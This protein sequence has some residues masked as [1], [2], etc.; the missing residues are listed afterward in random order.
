MLPERAHN[1]RSNVAPPED[2]KPQWN[3]CPINSAVLCLGANMWRLEDGCTAL[4]LTWRYSCLHPTYTL[5]S[6]LF[7]GHDFGKGRLAHARCQQTA[8]FFAPSQCCLL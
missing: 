4:S 1:P 8:G 7:F 3:S 5:Q 6:S 2:A